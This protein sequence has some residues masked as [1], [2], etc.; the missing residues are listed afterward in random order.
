[1]RSG[2]FEMQVAW[3]EEFNTHYLLCDYNRDSDSYRSIN[4]DYLPNVWCC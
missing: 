2:L 3:D 1:M 4:V